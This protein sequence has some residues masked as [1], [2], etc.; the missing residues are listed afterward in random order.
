MSFHFTLSG[1]LRL[2]E[3]LER[4]ELQRLQLIAKAVALVRVEIESLETDMDAMRR[5]RSDAMVTAGITG[6]ELHFGE[7]REVAL[8]VLRSELLKRLL[9]LEAKRKEQQAR[10]LQSRM[11]REILSN[12]YKRQ[13]AEYK[14]NQSRQD[15]RLI[16]ELFLIR[17][18]SSVK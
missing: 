15:Q 4:A 7:A 16:D 12:L 1:F 14:L 9:D 3:S 11:Q 13:L 2:R 10:Y 6:A 18:I 17:S 8:D 5:S